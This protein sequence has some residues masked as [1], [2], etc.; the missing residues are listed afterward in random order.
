MFLDEMTFYEVSEILKSMPFFNKNGWEQARMIAW[1]IAQANS[2]K[3]IDIKDMGRFA[4]EEEDA[5]PKEIT[6]KEDERLREKAK[7]IKEQW[8]T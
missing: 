4:W 8:Q 1:T 3:T 5:K 7:R 2:T 6:E